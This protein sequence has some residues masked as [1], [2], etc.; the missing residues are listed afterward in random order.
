MRIPL[1]EEPRRNGVYAA[2]VSN[3]AFAVNGVA[4]DKQASFGRNDGVWAR[5]V[6]ESVDTVRATFLFSNLTR[7][8]MTQFRACDG[9]HVSR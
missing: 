4:F 1:T 7:E 5:V 2:Y 9:Q 3:V 6:V 8:L